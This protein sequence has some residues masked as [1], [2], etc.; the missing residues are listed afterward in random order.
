MTPATNPTFGL[1]CDRFGINFRVK[2]FHEPTHPSISKNARS[3]RE[4]YGKVLRIRPEIGGDTIA[5]AD[6]TTSDTSSVEWLY[7]TNSTWVTISGEIVTV[8]GLHFFEDNFWVSIVRVL[9]PVV[10]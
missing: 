8:L 6:S 10:S 7:P 2:L 4:A 5:T 3:D 9:V 1:S